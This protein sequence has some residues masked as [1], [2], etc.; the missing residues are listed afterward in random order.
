MSGIEELDGEKNLAPV[1]DIK[2]G[3]LGKLNTNINLT[4]GRYS[5]LKIFDIA[6]YEGRPLYAAAPMVRYSKVHLSV[7][8]SFIDHVAKTFYDS[9]H[10]ERLLHSTALIYVGRPWSVI[11]YSSTM[12]E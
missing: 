7:M 2:C 6:K 9:L 3:C 11:V 10:F 4:D 1:L 12:S 8:I 5:P